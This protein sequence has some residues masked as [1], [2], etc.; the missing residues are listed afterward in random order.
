VR[1]GG[2]LFIVAGIG[3]AVV[4]ILLAIVAIRGGDEGDTDDPPIEPAAEMTVVEALRD[5]P[6][7][8][9][10][11]DQDVRAMRVPVTQA[12]T[13]SLSSAGEVLGQAYRMPLVAGQRLLSAEVE[14][15]GLAS[16]IR[17][18][19]RAISVPADTMSL[20]SGLIQ[21]DAFVD[22]VYRGRI[23]VVRL[24][25]SAIGPLA[26]DEVT[27][28][29]EMDDNFGWV[30]IDFIDEF[31]PYPPVGLEEA[32]LQAPFV[33]RVVVPMFRRLA[34]IIAARAPQR[35]FDQSKHKLEE[36]GNLGHIGAGE[37]LG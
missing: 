32:E 8:R 5:V 25:G 23:N 6:A 9:V 28:A 3:L 16:E 10:I 35:R 24:L 36:A 15:P 18:G 33:R 30:R 11:T 14:Q 1:G 37:F 12:A 21:D 17:P 2:R 26:E 34:V 4:A 29:P 20:L 19:Y 7:H 31:P 22:V 13:G 27:Y